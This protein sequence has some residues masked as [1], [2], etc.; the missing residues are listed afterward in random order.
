MTVWAEEPR[1]GGSAVW[2][3][4]TCSLGGWCSDHTSAFMEARTHARGHREK[5]TIHGQPRRGPRIDPDRDQRI[6]ELRAT[7]TLRAIGVIVGLSAAGVAKA[8]ARRTS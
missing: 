7:H 2:G 8:I 1:D 5:V 4:N 6:L 3:C